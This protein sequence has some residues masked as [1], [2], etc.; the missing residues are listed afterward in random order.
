MAKMQQ[1]ELEITERED[2]DDD[3]TVGEPF[4]V[5]IPGYE[6]DEG[7]EREEGHWLVVQPPTLSRFMM[8]LMA[9]EGAEEDMQVASTAM[10]LI[11]S[12]IDAGERIHIRRR[13]NSD[14]DPLRLDDLSGI[15]PMMTESWS[16]RPTK[17]PSGSS[18]SPPKRGRASTPKRPSK[19]AT[20]SANSTSDDS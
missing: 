13:F 18:S 2:R 19:A 9:Y 7:Y 1:F 4:E 10:Q 17:K 16:T 5:W 8:L 11:F 12:C 3:P 15:I 14:D 20:S 6:D